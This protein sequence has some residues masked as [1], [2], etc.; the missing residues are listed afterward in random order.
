MALEGLNRLEV[1]QDAQRLVE[2]V[3]QR[4]IPALP[5]EE[6]WGLASQIRRA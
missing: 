4:V 6:K 1:Y 3:Y 2:V 5:S